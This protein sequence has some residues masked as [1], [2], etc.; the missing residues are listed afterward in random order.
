M[1]P[2][3]EPTSTPPTVTLT[4]RFSI[5]DTERVDA[6]CARLGISRTKLIRHCTMLGLREVERAS[7]VIESPLVGAM[8]QIFADFGPDEVS[9]EFRKIRSQ[10]RGT[11]DSG[12]Q[13]KFP[14]VH[15]NPSDLGV[16]C[17][18]GNT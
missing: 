18:L 7:A 12:D 11:D 10:L 8:L 14:F 13:V 16:D 4:S 6:A 1:T 2:A 3:L 15:D 9:D 5:S 17:G